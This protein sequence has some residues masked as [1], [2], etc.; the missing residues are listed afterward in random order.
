[1]HNRLAKILD[2]MQIDY[3]W[4]YLI[5][6]LNKTM[7]HVRDAMNGWESQQKNRLISSVPK[8]PDLEDLEC[9]RQ[10]KPCEGFRSVPSP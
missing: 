6:I 2:T 10:L 5:D 1:M 8:V 4:Y 9:L 7:R 3:A